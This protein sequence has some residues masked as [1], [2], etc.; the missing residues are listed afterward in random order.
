MPQPAREESGI[1]IRSQQVRDQLINNR[2]NV[3]SSEK[4]CVGGLAPLLC[5]LGL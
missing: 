2:E 1:C 4:T 3:S 5:C